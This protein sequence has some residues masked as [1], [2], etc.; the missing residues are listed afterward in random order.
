MDWLSNSYVVLTTN[1][2]TISYTIDRLDN[3]KY[4][5]NIL[6]FIQ[7]TDKS[8]EN[9]KTSKLENEDWLIKLPENIKE[10]L[11]IS[12]KL[13]TIIVQRQVYDSFGNK[14]GLNNLKIGESNGTKKLLALSALLID[15]LQ[16]GKTLVIDEL[17]ASLHPIIVRFILNLFHS[18]ETNPH[19]AQLIFATHDTHL[20]SPRFFRRDQIWFTEKNQQGV[21]DLYSLADFDISKDDYQQDYFKGKY[22]AIPYI[23]GDFEIFSKEGENCEK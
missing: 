17:E 3:E 9:I 10:E 15:I 16:E 1:S 4:K 18:P 13:K 12:R 19:N 14:K 22:G 20:L 5:N 2:L 8:I 11:M 7:Q 23:G 21:T 6:N